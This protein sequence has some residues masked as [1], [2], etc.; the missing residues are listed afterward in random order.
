LAIA[1]GHFI[2]LVGSI[3][4]IVAIPWMAA[5]EKNMEPR[6]FLW[7]S[8][9]STARFLEDQLSRPVADSVSEITDTSP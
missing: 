3:F 8:E 5:H 9:I 4:I 2:L 1:V 6:R 7:S